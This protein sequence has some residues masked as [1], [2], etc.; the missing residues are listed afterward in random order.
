M[1]PIAPFPPRLCSTTLLNSAQLLR[2]I[3]THSCHSGLPGP[4]CQGG[5]C[6][7]SSCLVL[8]PLR[9]SIQ[10]LLRVSCK[11]MGRRSQSSQYGR[12]VF[13]MIIFTWFLRFCSRSM[14]P[15]FLLRWHLESKLHSCFLLIFLYEGTSKS[16]LMGFPP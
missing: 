1:T 11:F 10:A 6:L 15:V 14:V 3:M 7:F 12:A 5:C 8:P 4:G 2:A 13:K 9:I 16:I